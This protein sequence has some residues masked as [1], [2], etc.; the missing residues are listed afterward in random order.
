[1]SLIAAGSAAREAARKSCHSIKLIGIKECIHCKAYTSYMLCKL[2]FPPSTKF[3]GKFVNSTRMQQY[4][5]ELTRS[6]QIIVR[7]EFCPREIGRTRLEAVIP[8]F[9]KINYL[10]YGI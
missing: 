4:I 10:P 8:S 5:A 2:V 6:E 3:D 7:W 9:R 1:M